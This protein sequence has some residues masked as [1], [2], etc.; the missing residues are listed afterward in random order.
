MTDQQWLN[1]LLFAPMFTICNIR[2][3]LKYSYTLLG[4]NNDILKYLNYF[5][6]L[7]DLANTIVNFYSIEEE[8]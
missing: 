8:I 1:T 6:R 4:R 5:L 7:V 2:I 3:Y